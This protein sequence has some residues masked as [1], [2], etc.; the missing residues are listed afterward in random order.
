MKIESIEY[1]NDDIVIIMDHKV[2]D[3]GKV[4]DIVYKTKHTLKEDDFYD[5]LNGI[6]IHT[7]PCPVMELMTKDKFDKIFYA[8]KDKEKSLN[9]KNMIKRVQEKDDK[10][11]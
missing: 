9:F 11:I 8:I 3:D 2:H 7:R 4:S 6:G 5:V 1:K 10:E